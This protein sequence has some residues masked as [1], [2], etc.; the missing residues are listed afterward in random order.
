MSRT[1]WRCF[2]IHNP[3][4]GPEDVCAR[5]IIDGFAYNDKRVAPILLSENVGYAGAVNRLFKEAETEYIAYLDND[6][7]ILTEGWDE[8]LCS[9]LDRFHE[10]GMIFPNGGAYPIDRGPYLEIMWG[11]G[12]A[13]VINRMA[14]SDTGKFDESLGHQDECDYALR[15]RMAGWKCAAAP[16]VS[17]G[18]LATATNDPAA[19][20]RINRGVVRFVDKWNAYFNGGNFHYHSPNVTRWD[21]WPPNAL[22]LEEMWRAKLPGLNDAP[23]VVAIDGR[24]YDLI[25][26]PRFSGFYRGRII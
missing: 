19:I 26:V 16:D 14:M 13:W 15:L 3:S 2:V 10:I 12:F 1:D 24:E 5:A 25:K 9:Y 18:H 21:D 23:E 22:Y 11:V 7:R 4:D 17:I 8:K 6:V 20:E